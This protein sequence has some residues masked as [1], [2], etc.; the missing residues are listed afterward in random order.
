M[1]YDKKGS[2]SGPSTAGQNTLALSLWHQGHHSHPVAPRPSRQ[3]EG[4]KQETWRLH[5]LRVGFS[6]VCVGGG[7]VG[8]IYK[9]Q[10]V[11]QP[12]S[13]TPQSL[14][15]SL[16]HTALLG[17]GTLP[18]ETRN[19]QLSCEKKQALLSH[20]PSSPSPAQSWFPGDGLSG[21]QQ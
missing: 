5:S 10:G 20:S 9:R 14:H 12:S 15:C 13:L 18:S 16:V 4:N 3:V 7:G 21:G 19:T 1:S 17:E 8:A 11:K 6:A 2:P